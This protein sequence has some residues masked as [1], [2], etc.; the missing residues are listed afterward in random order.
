MAIENLLMF[1]AS[2]LT[3]MA[4]GISL[5]TARLHTLTCTEGQ[6]AVSAS[7]PGWMVHDG[8]W[9]MSDPEHPSITYEQYEFIQYMKIHTCIDLNIQYYNI[10]YIYTYYI[11][12]ILYVYILYI[13]VLF[14]TYLGHPSQSSSSSP[15]HS[16]CTKTC[17]SPG[18]RTGQEEMKH[19]S[20]DQH[21]QPLMNHIMSYH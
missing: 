3:S 4:W 8:A 11:Y 6:V 5:S 14:Y 17:V 21:Y 19:Q 16:L 18:F 1:P 10:I 20:I 12:I 2:Q 13:Y 7:L 9:V 15:S